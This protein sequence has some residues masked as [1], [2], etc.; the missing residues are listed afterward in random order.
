MA[1]QQLSEESEH[2]VGT[3][4]L[5]CYGQIGLKG[6]HEDPFPWGGPILLHPPTVPTVATPELVIGME[7]FLSLV[8][9]TRQEVMLVIGDRQILTPALCILAGTTLL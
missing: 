7:V 6:R 9:A 5:D 1:E 4:K 3:G 2:P 8:S